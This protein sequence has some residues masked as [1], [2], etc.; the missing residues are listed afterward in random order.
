MNVYIAPLK[1]TIRTIFEMERYPKCCAECPA[2]RTEEYQCH[3]E[4]GEVGVCLLGY[5][6]HSDTRDFYGRT[7]FEK[8]KIEE[9]PNVTIVEGLE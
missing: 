2:F 5:M 6:E 4:R 3:N 9:N 1:H 7:R 8:C